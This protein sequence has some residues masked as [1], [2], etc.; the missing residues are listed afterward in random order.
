M[1]QRVFAMVEEAQA[2]LLLNVKY[3][4]YVHQLVLC[5]SKYVIFKHSYII[6]FYHENWGILLHCQRG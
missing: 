5:T 3:A 1:V 2:A 6:T 4:V